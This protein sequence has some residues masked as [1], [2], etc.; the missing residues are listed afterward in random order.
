LSKEIYIS[1]FSGTPVNMAGMRK[2]RGP[3]PLSVPY[4]PYAKGGHEITIELE[5]RRK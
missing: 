1:A 2:R 3:V 4:L 5:E